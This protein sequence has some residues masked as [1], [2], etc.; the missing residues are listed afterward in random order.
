VQHL[1]TEPRDDQGLRATTTAEIAQDARRTCAGQ[2]QSTTTFDGARS[3]L[4]QRL[5]RLDDE[6]PLGATLLL[7]QQSEL[8][9][10]G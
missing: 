6:H 4:D 1:D 9:L 5:D 10:P 8:F 2:C 3:V 7:Q